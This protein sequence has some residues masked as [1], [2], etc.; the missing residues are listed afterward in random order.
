MHRIKIPARINELASV[1]VD[2][3]LA[4]HRELGPGLLESAYETCLA[5]ELE[6]RDV[7]F[8]RQCEVPLL[9]KGVSVAAGFRADIIIENV[10]ILELK[11]VDSLLPIHEAQLITYL[12][13]M[14]LPLGM[15][16]NFNVPLVREG[17]QRVLNLYWKAPTDTCFPSAL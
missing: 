6:L 1:A 4:V 9:Y 15:L 5:R 16:V 8:Q 12:K 17:I 10:L 3:C 7:S 14:D 11:A 2:A 13:L